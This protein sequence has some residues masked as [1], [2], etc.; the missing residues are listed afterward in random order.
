MNVDHF[1]YATPSNYKNI[2]AV[3]LTQAVSML[4]Q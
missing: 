2:N 1:L 4:D 3:T